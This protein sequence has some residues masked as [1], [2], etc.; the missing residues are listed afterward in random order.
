ME[1]KI[2]VDIQESG[3]YDLPK[4]STEGS[5][6]ID[7]SS[8]EE[9]LIMPG[10]H[11]MVK[12]GIT[13]RIQKGYEIQVRSRSGLAY[14]HGVSVL[15]SPGTIDSDYRGK[16]GV[17]LINHGKSPFKVNVGDRIAQLVLAKVETIEWNVVATIGSEETERGSGGYGSTG[18]DKLRGST[19]L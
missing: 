3:Y 9:L 18:T 12:T 13:V 1:N 2:V 14:K 11:S 5:A 6:G 8:T 10:E 17:I 16:I 19:P 15:N 4:Y 7:V